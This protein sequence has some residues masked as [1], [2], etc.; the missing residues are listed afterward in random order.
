MVSS[1]ATDRA[2]LTLSPEEADA[3]AGAASAYA[4]VLPPGRAAPYQALAEAAADG[5]IPDELVD[6]AERVAAVSLQ[7]GRAR[8]DGQAGDER[9]LA[10]VYRRTP[11]GR[12][13]AGRASEVNQALEVLAGRP[14]RTARVAAPA[15]GSY[16]LTLEAGGVQVTLAI[17]A[18]GIEVRS[19]ETG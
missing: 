6:A 16:T 19:L 4:A 5:L 9:L 13:L 15:P 3:V 2:G 10:A 18:D 8:R 11:A 1:Q 14:L 17:N 7:T 12:A